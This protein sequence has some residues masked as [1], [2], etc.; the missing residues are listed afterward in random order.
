MNPTEPREPAHTL[1]EQL[2]A[3][4]EAERKQIIAESCER[5][6]RDVE[7]L[8]KRSVLPIEGAD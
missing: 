1:R 5:I 8:L 3:L 6:L 7:E 2:A 4:R